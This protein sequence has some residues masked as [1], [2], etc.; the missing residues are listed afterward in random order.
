MPLL[1]EHVFV[2]WRDLAGDFEH[3]NEGEEGVEV[4]V[5]R[6]HGGAKNS[7]KNYDFLKQAPSKEGH[8]Y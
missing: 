4:E 3:D 8:T 2:A 6:D 5:D 7:A 1:D